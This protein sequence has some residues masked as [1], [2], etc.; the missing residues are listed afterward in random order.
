[1]NEFQASTEQHELLT[2]DRQNSEVKDFAQ[3]ISNSSE[4]TGK[5]K[6]EQLLLDE[7]EKLKL[8]RDKYLSEAEGFYIEMA[9]LEALLE[10]DEIIDANR[11]DQTRKLYNELKIPYDSRKHQANLESDRI[12]RREQ[13]LNHKT[14]MNRYIEL[15]AQSKANE[16]ELDEN[17]HSLNSRLK[18][19]QQQ[20]AEDISKARRAE[21]DAANA[22]ARA[23]AWGDN[24]GEKSAEVYAQKAAKNLATAIEHSRRQHL[25]I[26]ALE[27]ELVT[28]DQYIADV[29]KEHT[30]IEQKALLL[31]HTLLEEKWNDAA[32]ALLDVGG[33]LWA[34]YNMID[35]DQ[36]ALLKLKIPEEGER[37]GSWTWRELS[38]RACEYS[39]QDVL[40]A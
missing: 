34:S 24:E 10:N 21:T 36:V 33:K 26:A 9:P 18:Q 22:Y 11:L 4:A 2:D 6:K 12:I 30:T 31:A 28:V 17:R 14:L 1:M 20:E 16:Q 8:S 3:P 27:K 40:A 39:I 32:K 35:R 15:M 13:L 37:F 29:Q 23:V 5:S 19:I 25:I 7:I 38:E